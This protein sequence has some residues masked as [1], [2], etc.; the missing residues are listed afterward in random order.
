MKKKA[1]THTLDYDLNINGIICMFYNDEGPT[2]SIRTGTI[3]DFPNS[4]NFGNHIFR[5]QGFLGKKVRKIRKREMK[6]AMDMEIKATIVE[7]QGLNCYNKW[8]LE[9]PLMR[10]VVKLNVSYDMG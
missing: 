10:S 9:D 2:N 1:H 5:R 7:D 3:L 4:V 8:L 6:I